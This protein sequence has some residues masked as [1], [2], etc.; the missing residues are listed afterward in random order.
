MGFFFPSLF[1]TYATVLKSPLYLCNFVPYHRLILQVQ[2]WSL[3]N[4]C[5]GE[6]Q[7]KKLKTDWF[8]RQMDKTYPEIGKPFANVPLFLYEITLQNV[9]NSALF[10]CWKAVKL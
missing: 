1:F 6:D 10:C 5:I 8:W 9:P 4:C 2:E 3:L 7:L